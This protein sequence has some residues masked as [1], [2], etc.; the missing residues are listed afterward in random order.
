MEV[1]VVKNITFLIVA[2]ACI[3]A[4]PLFKKTAQ[5]SFAGMGLY[6]FWVMSHLLVAVLLYEPFG[7]SAWGFLC[8]IFK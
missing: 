7:F 2:A 8:E 5:P 1:Q 6:L 3:V 4:V